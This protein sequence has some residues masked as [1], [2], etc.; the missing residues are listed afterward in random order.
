[1][2]FLRRLV[3]LDEGVADDRPDRRPPPTWPPAGSAPPPAPAAPLPPRTGP[4]RLAALAPVESFG[5]VPGP[6]GGAAVLAALQRCDDAVDEASAQ[7]AAR[8]VAAACG[9]PV[10]RAVV[11]SALLTTTLL[12]GG[13]L[14]EL[15][16]WPA[17][18]AALALAEVSGWRG[19]VPGW[20]D[21]RDAGAGLAL[22]ELV[23]SWAP[24]W[25]RV[26][27]DEIAPTLP[28]DGAARAARV[29]T[30]LQGDP[31]APPAA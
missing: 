13:L 20:E 15:P 23:A 22:P 27:A 25:R 31:G 2:S 6:P 30:A 7:D 18:A 17:R 4:V 28:P 19:V 29:A 11:P 21:H 26:V 5:T 10:A 1:M 14:E 16:P 8:A 3:G 9:D 12:V 24:E